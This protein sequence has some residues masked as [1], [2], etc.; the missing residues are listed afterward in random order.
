MR[1][2]DGARIASV[3]AALMAACSFDS[4]GEPPE[5]SGP[6]AG[7][8]CNLVMHD[9]LNVDPALLIGVDLEDCM[10]VCDKALAQPIVACEFPEEDETET[11]G[12]SGES[13]SSSGD[14]D[15]V[16]VRCDYQG[17]CLGRGHAALIG[18]AG[19]R[20]DGSVAQWLA[21]AARSE[22]ASVIAFLALARELR[23][24]GAPPE[25]IARCR[26]AAMDEVRHARSM[27]RLAAAHSIRPVSPHFDAVVEREFEAIAIENAIEG[28]VNET[29]AALE[30]T[31]QARC[32]G[33]RAIRRAM[34]RIA[35]EETRHARLSWD[36]DAWA[37][38]RLSHP[39]R[40][41]VALARDEAFASLAKRLGAAG[42]ATLRAAA[43]LPDPD[44][45]HTLLAG[46]RRL[47]HAPRT[48]H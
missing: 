32:A 1:T 23:S 25:F 28:C 10:A 37:W 24:H 46:L 47:A 30:A 22:A 43:G 17:G 13:G 9:D 26:A 21:S 35:K 15:G 6:D 29:W 12:S 48:S 38:S 36:L 5:G 41:R 11:G 4:G 14:F 18:G 7:G 31:Y 3:F 45:A 39:A 19:V 33:D 40:R 16:R 44:R 34:Q 8:E 2:S 42:N 20:T 27:T